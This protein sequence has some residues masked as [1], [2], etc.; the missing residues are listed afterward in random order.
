MSQ[1]QSDTGSPRATEASGSALSPK[2]VNLSSTPIAPTAAAD[3]GSAPPEDK[4]KK[5]PTVSE[6]QTIV[7]ISAL[8]SQIEVCDSLHDSLRRFVE[9]LRNAIGCDDVVLGLTEAEESV[10]TLVAIASRPNLANSEDKNLE[11]QATLNEAV[12]RDT[13]TAWPP[14]DDQHRH[15]LLAHKQFAEVTRTK[16]LVSFPLKDPTGKLRGALLLVLK[17]NPLADRRA[18][19]IASLAASRIAAS[20][21]ILKK[22]DGDRI[23]R[24]VRKLTRMTRVRS[25][26]LWVG[27][28]LLAVVI[29][30]L[31]VPH[32]VSCECEVQPTVKRY[33]A[34]P[35]DVA[36]EEA[37][38]RAGEEV[39]AGDLLARLD[40]HEVA[41]ALTG[42]E[43]EI[44]QAM[45]RQNTQLAERDYGAARL[46][47]LEIDEITVRKQMLQ[48]RLDSLDVRSPIDG[49]IIEGDLQRAEGVQLSKGQTL[50]QVAPLDRMVVEIEVPE[51][52]I[53][54]IKTDMPVDVSL[55][56]DGWTERSGTVA[57]ILPSSQLRN[58]RNVFVAEIEVENSQNE[59]RPGMRG[60][61]EVTGDSAPLAWTMMRRPV[62]RLLFWLGW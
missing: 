40:G 33:V 57:R 34:A 13:V 24:A 20:M 21:A 44:Q 52:D 10:P 50:F 14:P 7:V 46:T 29:G 58:Q 41:L 55:E 25:T 4:T 22:A 59:L 3:P 2:M 32:S 23:S 6:L 27:L 35:F 47:Q 51:S 18:L 17:K 53:R 36:V 19:Q 38:V 61:A 1:S 12:I 60:Y 62:H 8:L 5:S 28:L 45:K 31:P 9:G 37:F 54:L 49:V 56:A 16:G 26:T 42:V 30:L 43:S 48:H 39:E 15:A 11:I